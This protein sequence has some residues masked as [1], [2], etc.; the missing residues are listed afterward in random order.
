MAD[1]LARVATAGLIAALLGPALAAPARSVDGALDHRTM[2]HL[3]ARPY[4][5]LSLDRLE[6]GD[7]GDGDTLLWDVEG[8]YG[9]DYNKLWLELDAEGPDDESPERAELSVLYD[10][11]FSPF[12]SWRAGVRYDVRARGRP[13]IGYAVVGLQG[14]APYWFETDVALYLSEDGDLGLHMELEHDIRLTQRLILQPRVEVELRADDVPELGVGS[15]LS[16]SGL[17]LRLRYEIAREFAPYIGLRRERLHG[18][19]RDFAHAAGESSSRTSLVL[20][21]KAWL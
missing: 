5:M 6:Y 16:S 7:S 2:A 9:G 19:S 8:W 11:A 1:R 14:L 21:I 15:G 20:G 18:D 4:G 12:W 13:D 3:D 10:R 17:G